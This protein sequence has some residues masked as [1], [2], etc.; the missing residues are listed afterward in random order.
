VIPPAPW[1]VGIV[2]QVPPVAS[3]YAA[4]TSSLGHEP[5]V[6]IS[7][8]RRRAGDP[9]TPAGDGVLTAAPEGLDVVFA[10]SKRSLAPLFR[11]YELDLVLLTGFPWLLPA[12]AIA[13]P[14]LGIVNG[15]PSLLPRYRGPMPVA[16]AIRNGETEIGL[17]YH[18]VDEHF[19][20][21]P[22][23]A[24]APVTLEYGD[25]WDSLGPQLEARSAELLTLVFEK[26][27]AGDRG[28][29]QERGEYQSYFED[30]YVPVDLSQPAEHIHRQVWAW[31]FAPPSAGELGPI[32]EQDGQRRRLLKTS[33]TEVEEAERLECADGPLWILESEPA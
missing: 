12:E 9:P 30:D 31:S 20:T 27:A 28:T 17:S 11:F 24:Q 32:L 23:L 25:T 5:V 29:V 1:R 13:V 16:W 19:D 2:T 8:R 4:I 33:L 7:S 22:L 26:L 15:H 6:V 14:P 3:G 18:L 21:G 10:D